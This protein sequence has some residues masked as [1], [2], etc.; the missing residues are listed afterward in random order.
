MKERLPFA[1]DLATTAMGIMPH[2]S[3]GPALKA[4]LGLEIPFWPQL[5]RLSFHED[6]YVQAMEHF[7]GVVIDEVNRRIYVE[8]GRFMD[9]LPAYL[10]QEASPDLFRLS[11]DF[12]SVYRRFLALDLSCCKAIRGQVISP[13]SL[14]LGISD[15]QGKPVAYNDELR[16]LVFSFIQKKVNVQYA[17]LAEKNSRAFVWLDDP[18]LQFVFN[19]MSGYDNVTAKADLVGFFNGIDGPRG[20]HL[21]GNPDWDFLF[22]LPLEIISFNAYAFGDIVA[23]YPSV[24]RF[25][26]A[27]NMVSWGIV[28][29][30]FEEFTR[31]DVT[32]IAGRLLA[33]WRLLEEKGVPRD[34]I[35][36]NSLI[37]PATCN[38]L[39]AD[40]T[41]TVD[42]AFRLLREV[43]QYVQGHCL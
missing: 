36:R 30:L 25:I 14:V 21:C 23:T 11:S 1:G 16:G 6:M 32:T 19:A 42:N 13:V 27:G 24:R 29:T 37:A 10:E 7:P 9:E 31:E 43:S 35:C 26:E 17:E 33:M 22:S 40:N 3:P 34:I 2:E 5:P 39:N 41:T 28:P 12:S 8:S 38:L 15:E 18:G 20:I 4:A